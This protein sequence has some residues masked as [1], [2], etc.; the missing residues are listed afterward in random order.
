MFLLL[1]ISCQK[2]NDFE[3]AVRKAVADQMERYPEST[4][5]DVYKNFFQDKF[6]PGHIIDDTDAASRYLLQELDSYTDASGEIAEPTGW[7]HNFYRVNLSVIKDRTVPY[8]VF[9]DAFVRSVNGIEPVS[10]EEWRKEW[11]GIEAIIRSMNLSLPDYEADNDEINARLKDGK[12]V[13]HHSEHFEKA[14]RPHYRIV[15][16]K[17]YE[18]ELKPLLRNN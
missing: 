13:G 8:E 10:I 18:D 12:Y 3:K 15:S 17:I 1:F 7:Q 5:K 16:K 11:A 4:L 14:Y 6:G 2:D 9:L